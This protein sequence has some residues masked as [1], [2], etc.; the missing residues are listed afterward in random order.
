MTQQ[1]HDRIVEALR[2]LLPD[3]E[4]AELGA[5]QHRALAGGVNRR[6]F[7]VELG[8]ERW[9]LQ[10]PMPGAPALLDVATEAE[11]R[12]AAAAAGLAPAVVGVDM[13]NGALLTEYRSGAVPWTAA[14][15]REPANIVRAAR[16][17]R[18]LHAVDA[19]VP[20]YNAERISR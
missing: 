13:P 10:L 4:P 2:R 7:L 14:D 15:A 6:T 20:P 16:L 5:A 9:V 18:A 11:A 1:P 17:L 3:R 12:R 8:A 19:P